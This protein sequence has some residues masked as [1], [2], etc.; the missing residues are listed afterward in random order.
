M[1]NR[2][3]YNVFRINAFRRQTPGKRFLSVALLVGAIWS[4]R[5]LHA[6]DA[7]PVIFD[8]DMAS[9][10]DDAGALAVLHAL[11]DNGE[12]NILAVVTNRKNL[13]YA[14]AAACDVINTYYGRP[15]IPIGTDKDGAKSKWNKPSS[16]TPLLR[17]EFLH[18]T[19][20][21]E[22]CPD[23]TA[24]Y[25]TALAA[26]TDRSVTICSVG[27]LSNLEDLLRSLPDAASPLSGVDLVKLKVKRTV[28]MGGGFPRTHRPETNLLLDPAAVVTVVNE[29]PGPIIWQGY[30]VGAALHCGSDLKQ[31]P[32]SNPVRR[33]FE[34][35]PYL[36]QTA[37]KDGK[38]AHD[39][40]AVLIAIRGAT[41]DLWKVVRG[42]RVVV[43]SD[44]QTEWKT[45]KVGNHTYVAIKDHPHTL[46]K[47]IEDLMSQPP[48]AK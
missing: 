36:G 1:T 2:S 8:T 43:D 23:A 9:D 14:S 12:A 41:N 39:Q 34:T 5:T 13:A 21:D 6:S 37:L 44:G 7:V 28:I 40:A 32:T 46:T 11:A 26:A 18:D 17:D 29:W 20:A 33:A 30:E 48:R 47:I 24:V 19:P 22:D 4:T 10:C 15:N 16:Y 3:L 31:T 42:G 25:R 45:D 27:A 38:P 35:R